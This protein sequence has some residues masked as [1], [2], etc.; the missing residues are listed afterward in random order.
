MLKVADIVREVSI[1]RDEIV[2]GIYHGPVLVNRR[3][4]VGFSKNIVCPKSRIGWLM[5]LSTSYASRLCWTRTRNIHT[6][7]S[8]EALPSQRNWIRL[9]CHAV[10]IV[11]AC[12]AAIFLTKSIR[13]ALHT[14][15]YVIVVQFGLKGRRTM[16]RPSEWR[17]RRVVTVV[18][19]PTILKG[20]DTPARPTKDSPKD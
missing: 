16:P 4:G 3:G 19:A 20:Y 12:E 11:T 10:S 14:V 18:E 1:F 9:P 15:A 7:V 2:R 13:I 8:M 5:P 6:A 17:R